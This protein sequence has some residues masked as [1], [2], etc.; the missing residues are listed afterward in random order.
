MLTV[1]YPVLIT[2]KTLRDAIGIHMMPRGKKIEDLFKQCVMHETC[3]FIA[4]SK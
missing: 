2:A 4:F 1:K 3:N